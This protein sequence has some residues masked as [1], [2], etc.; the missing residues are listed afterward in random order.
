VLGAADARERLLLEGHL[1]DCPVCS[2]EMAHLAPLPELL[3]QVPMN[4]VPRYA[5]PRRRR[6]RARARR[7]MPPRVSLMAALAAVAAVA[8]AAGIAGG[9]ALTGRDGSPPRAPASAGRS[10]AAHSIAFSGENPAT[11]VRATAVL[12]P[13]SWGTRIELWLNGAPLNKNCRLIVVVRGGASEDAGIWQAWQRGPI[14]VP[15]SAAWH[16]SDIITLK[17]MA[18]KQDLA[19]LTAAAAHG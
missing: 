17:I 15:A 5:P 14:T 13:T 10:A 2:E 3:A 1:R 11:H 7:R 19:T 6:S 16:A 18:G 9:L 8:V 4:L 12:T